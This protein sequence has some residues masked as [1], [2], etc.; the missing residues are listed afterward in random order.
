LDLPYGRGY[1]NGADWDRLFSEEEMT[2]LFNQINTTCVP[3]FMLVIGHAIEW[4]HLVYNQLHRIGWNDYRD[5]NA[6]YINRS[7]MINQVYLSNT[8]Y[9]TVVFVPDSTNPIFKNTDFV[10]RINTLVFSDRTAKS[11]RQ[12]DGKTL[13]NYGEKEPCF[14][15]VMIQR[16]L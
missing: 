5:V 10:E 11:I 13:V 4:T 1:P 16:H 6:C 12:E 14:S 3:P 8:D 7:S 9:H 15:R 2:T